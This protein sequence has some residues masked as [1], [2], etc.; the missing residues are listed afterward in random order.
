[1]TSGT[2][3]AA[4]TGASQGIPSIAVSQQAHHADVFEPQSEIDFGVAADVTRAL[5]SHVLMH[6]MP[7]NVDALNVNIPMNVARPKYQVTRLERNVF[8]IRIIERLDPR[9]NAYFWI[10]SDFKQS[11]TP[12]TDM[13]ALN[14]GYISVTPLTLDNTV[15]SSETTLHEWLH[16]LPRL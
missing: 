9:G 12:G 5:V 7:S 4:L 16:T 1:M 14:N 8:D 10:G 15:R 2:V 6:D 11:E 3:G 13:Y